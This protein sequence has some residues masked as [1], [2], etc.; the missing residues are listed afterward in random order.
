MTAENST[1]VVTSNEEKFETAKEVFGDFLSLYRE[2]IELT[3]IQSVSLKR[4]TEKKAVAAYET[5]QEPVI[6][7]DFG[8]Y[9]DEFRRF[10]GPLIKLLLGETGLDG[11]KALYRMAGDQCEMVCSATYYDGTDMI[12]RQGKLQGT[13]RFSEANP[14]SDML[15]ST[16]FVPSGHDTTLANLD[17]KTHRHQAYQALRNALSEK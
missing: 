2:D 8:F 5:C 4:V 17:I 1:I 14:T 12:L 7:D 6:I 3:E 16:I 13:L 10:P 11:I 15:L 9:F